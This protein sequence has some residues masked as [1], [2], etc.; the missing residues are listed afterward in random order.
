LASEKLLPAV[1]DALI[2]NDIF[3][4]DHCPVGVLVNVN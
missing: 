1:E 4:S 3:G 2:Y